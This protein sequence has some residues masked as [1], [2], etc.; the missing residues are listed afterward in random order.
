MVAGMFSW[1]QERFLVSLSCPW[2]H[3]VSHMGK[4]RLENKEVVPRLLHQTE[5]QTSARSGLC[6]CHQPSRWESA[7][8]RTQ[9]PGRAGAQGLGHPWR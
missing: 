2:C 1:E 5:L 7:G 8:D 4:L 3:P 9:G 6:L